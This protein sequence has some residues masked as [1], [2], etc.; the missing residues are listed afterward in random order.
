MT[1]PRGFTLI[2]LMIVVAIIAILA[3]VAL[4]SYISYVQR[5]RIVDATNQLTTMRV[6][7]EQ[8]YQDNRSYGSTASACGVANPANTD[9]FVFSCTWGTTSSNQS[10]LITATGQA[11][12]NGYTFT[13]D[14]ANTRQTTAFPGT[15]VPQNCWISR[16]GQTC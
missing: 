8:F 9:S 5:G 7:L 6:R 10:F 3:A 2:E 4:P 1:N 12:M 16:A 13:I 14:E 15:T 11:T